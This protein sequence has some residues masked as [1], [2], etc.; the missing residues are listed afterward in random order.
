M[1][2]CPHHT[3]HVTK[4]HA[5]ILSQHNEIKETRQTLDANR[6]E[7]SQ[8]NARI[9]DLE[10]QLTAYKEHIRS[11]EDAL[12]HTRHALGTAQTSGDMARLEAKS[13]EF[14][15]TDPTTEAKH[16]VNRIDP[17]LDTTGKTLS[18]LFVIITDAI[19]DG[20][21]KDSFETV[22]IWYKR[23]MLSLIMPVER[24]KVAQYSETELN[25]KW[26]QLKK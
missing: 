8:L 5:K 25:T 11:T 4:L 12:L 21:A 20:R 1:T 17:G 19:R 16:Y 13:R 15:I 14:S 23:I 10:R 24:S 7:I 9:I 26:Y 18:E 6:N 2:L 3:H 22:P